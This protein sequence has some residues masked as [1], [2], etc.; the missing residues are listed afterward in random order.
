MSE[1]VRDVVVKETGI[2]ES[3]KTKRRLRNL[4]IPRRKSVTFIV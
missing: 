3:A 4:M 1:A 2:N